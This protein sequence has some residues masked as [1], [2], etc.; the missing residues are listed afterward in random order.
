[1]ILVCYD[2]SSDAQAAIDRAAT[3][4]P[5]AD[6]TVMVIWETILETTTRTGSLGM[7]LGM[8]GAYGDGDVDAK[9]KQAA[10][11]TAGEG[12]QRA[13]AAGLVAQPCV[14]SRDGDI[15]AVILSVAADVNA[16][17]IVLGTRGRSGVKSMMLGSV[18]QSVLHHADRP[19]LVVPSP[20]VCEQRRQWAEH[21]GIFAGASET[22]ADSATGSSIGHLRRAGTAAARTDIE[23]QGASTSDAP[24]DPNVETAP[25][26][27]GPV[28]D[29]YSSDDPKALV[30]PRPVASLRGTR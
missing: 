16:D 27:D 1:M 6:A 13:D 8:V 19:V 21:A 10:L 22:T 4:M 17:V 18:S 3:L 28:G 11:D 5:G 7:G 25:T 23:N 9:I 29:S 30:H 2:G 20:G 26:T 12:V 15:T 24:P 14:A